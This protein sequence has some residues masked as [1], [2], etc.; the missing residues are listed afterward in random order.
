MIKYNYSVA[1]QSEVKIMSEHTFFKPTPLYKEYL[2]L[3]LIENEKIITQRL[4]SDFL[5]VS[6][7]M[8]NTYLDDYEKKKYIKREYVNTKTVYYKITKKG[9]ERKKV[10]NIRYL[11]SSY[12]IY[13]GAKRNIDNF[14]GKIIGK[15]FK[16]ILLYGGGEVAEILLQSISTDRTIPLKIVAVIDDDIARYGTFLLHTKVINNREINQYEHDGILIS[17]YI[18]REA[19]YS[20]LINLGYD[21]NKIIQFFN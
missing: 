20:N 10:L 9:I 7:S 15:G 12:N 18:H 4:M 6:V 21:K 14:I 16:Q 1:E 8:I 5:G 2:I 17:S 19:I 13:Q 11:E 3:D